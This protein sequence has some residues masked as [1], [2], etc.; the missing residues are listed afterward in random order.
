[1]SG[2][3]VIAEVSDTLI[4]ALNT[5][6]ASIFPA[7][8]PTAVLHGLQGAIATNPPTLAVFLYEVTEDASTRNRPMQQVRIAPNNRVLRKPP[9]TLNLRYM[10][11]PFA[12][13]RATEQR[14]LG[15]SMQTV[16]DRSIYSGPELRGSIAPLGL[17]GSDN[18]LAVTLDPL[19]LEERTRVFHAVQRPYQ[20]SLSY[21]IRVANIDPISVNDIDLVRSR[22]VDP[23]VPERA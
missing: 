19:T 1:M 3:G 8:P 7:P 16:Y 17:V 9:L 12:G 20:L 10:I 15:A 23:A 6:L 14:M 4:N 2:S 13:D 11:V 18:N 22:N 5:A 21:Q